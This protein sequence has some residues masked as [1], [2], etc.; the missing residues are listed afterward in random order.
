MPDSPTALTGQ[1]RLRITDTPLRIRGTSPLATRSPNPCHNEMLVLAALLAVSP[2]TKASV[3]L[4]AAAEPFAKNWQR[5]VGSG[6]M[7]LGTRADWQS[8]LALAV[9]ELGFGAIRGHGLL[10]DD[11]GVLPAKG[12]LEFYNVDQARTRTRT[13]ARTHASDRAANGARSSTP[14]TPSASAPSSSSPSRP[15]PLLPAAKLASSRAT[16]RSAND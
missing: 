3:D 14:C 2:D 1:G 13:H 11:M 16:T 4:L 7:L 15:L 8:Q 5:C 9:N 12:R 10:D 6:H